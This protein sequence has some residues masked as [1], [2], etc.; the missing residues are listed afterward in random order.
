MTAPPPPGEDHAQ[1]DIEDAPG[2]GAAWGWVF[3]LSPLPWI[4]LIWWLLRP[5][6]EVD[7]PE[8]EQTQPPPPEQALEE[9]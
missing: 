1:K 9:E 7:R 3:I 6:A 4:L 8:V 5:A 2:S